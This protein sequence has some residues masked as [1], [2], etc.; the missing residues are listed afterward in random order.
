[1][2]TVI[3]VYALAAAINIII[4][5]AEITSWRIVTA[6]VDIGLTLLIAIYMG[7]SGTISASAAFIASIIVSIFINFGKRIPDIDMLIAKVRR[8]I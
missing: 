6:I 8:T 3:L 2:L 5:I 7:G 1:M 4:W